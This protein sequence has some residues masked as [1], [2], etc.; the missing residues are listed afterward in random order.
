MNT[1]ELYEK[2]C[3]IEGIKGDISFVENML[4][5]RFNDNVCIEAFSEDGD[6]YIGVEK[7]DMHFHPNEEDMFQELC[8]INDGEKIFV[9]K[10]G[11]FGRHIT[12]MYQRGFFEKY[13]WL[14][15]L[16]I[17]TRCYTSRG[18]IN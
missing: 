6:T 11:I 5:W 4:T 3:L 14:I 13:K 16:G 9:S 15:K 17:R 12:G 7:G 10:V 8:E 2:L 18:M 1:K